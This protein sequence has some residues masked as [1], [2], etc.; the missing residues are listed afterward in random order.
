MPNLPFTQKG[1]NSI[2][3]VHR[4]DFNSG[5]FDKIIK[6]NG[7]YNTYIKSLGGV[8]TKWVDKNTKVKPDYTVKNVTEFQECA[9][10][11]F[12]IMTMYGFNYTKGYKVWGSQDGDYADDAFYQSK[13]SYNGVSNGTYTTIDQIASGNTKGGMYVNCGFGVTYIYRKAGIIGNDKSEDMN[14]EREFYNDGSKLD[15]KYYRKNYD[16]TITDSMSPKKFKVGD[17]IGFYVSGSGFTY[18]HVAIVVAVNEKTGT[19]TLYDSG[20]SKFTK[21]RG[22]NLVIKM[23]D[24]LVGDGGIYSGYSSYKVMRLGKDYKGNKIPW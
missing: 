23:S 21:K 12:G 9:D 14:M 10:Y 8:F 22:N 1:T 15:N 24:K 16:A 11:V 4:Y 20:S 5:N 7:G 3:N 2:V 19:Y 18:R 13:K 6:A 17:I